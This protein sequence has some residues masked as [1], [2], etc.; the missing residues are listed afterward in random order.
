MNSKQPADNPC[1]TEPPPAGNDKPLQS[2]KEIAGY[3]D[4]D[5]RTAIRWEK[6]EGLPV[7]RHR[8]GGRGSVYAYPGELDAWRSRRKPRES[9]KKKLLRPRGALSAAA[10]I[11]LL[12]GVIWFVDNGPILN[13]P[14]PRAT[15]AG[16]VGMSTRLVSTKRLEPFPDGKRFSCTAWGGEGGEIAICD[17]ESGDVQQLSNNYRDGE[18]AYIS[19]V[20]PDSRW[21]AYS[22]IDNGTTELRIISTNTENS[23][24]TERRLFQ[25][26][27]EAYVHPFAITPDNKQVLAVLSRADGNNQLVFFSTAAGEITPIKSFD[28]RWPEARLSPDGRW[29]AYSLQ[30]DEGMPHTSIFLLAADGGREI[31]LVERSGLDYNPV[32]TPDGRAVLFA[33][34]RTG[35]IGLWRLSIRDDE[36]QG[37]PELVKSGLGRILPKAVT[38]NGSL[39]YDVYAK[40]QDVHVAG[41]GPGAASI[42]KPPRLATDRFIG[43]NFHPAWSPDGKHLAYFSSRHGLDLNRVPSLVVRSLESDDEVEHQLG[44]ARVAP[45]RWFPDSQSLLIPRQDMKRRWFLYQVDANSGEST[46]LTGPLR[47]DFRYPRPAVSPDGRTVYY[48]RWDDGGEAS[49][50]AQEVASGKTRELLRAPASQS[51]V[52]LAVSPKSGETAVLTSTIEA[53]DPWFHTNQATTVALSAIPSEGGEPRLIRSQKGVTSW[54]A[55]HDN[56]LEW[57]PDGEHLLLAAPGKTFGKF[58][59]VEATYFLLRFP[60]N[61]GKP[62]PVTVAEDWSATVRF[63][64]I[65]PDGKRLAFDTSTHGDGGGRRELWVLENFLAEKAPSD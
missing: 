16:I 46:K 11:A 6:E 22:V 31:S 32:F 45:G 4:R 37:A 5:V 3:L 17:L 24:K 57:T 13:P 47:T 42:V 20:S 53:G 54:R 15:A 58:Y 62:T 65:H 40:G 1:P 34:D 36:P 26:G 25:G 8:T 55:G 21:I 52:S 49:L 63:P 10:S 9:W 39:F 27:R 18:L 43:Q 2:W 19:V 51:I 61:G 50:L 33:S 29:I 30:P 12:A 56:G 41:L 59:G 44:F 64:A 28:W 7:R 23:A 60:A 38:Q 14:T 35:E 48:A